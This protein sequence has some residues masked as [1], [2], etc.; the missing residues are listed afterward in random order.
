LASRASTCASGIGAHRV[1]EAVVDRLEVVEVD[2]EHGD[3]LARSLRARQGVLEAI[4]EQRLVAQAPLLAGAVSGLAQ[5]HERRGV[6]GVQ[7]LGEARA[8]ELVGP[9]PSVA[10]TEPAW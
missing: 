1:P 6:V 5:P 2:E 10:S 4:G 7:P 3:G 9:R 8:Q